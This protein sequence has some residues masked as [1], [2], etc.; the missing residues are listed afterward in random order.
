MIC[1]GAEGPISSVY[2][3]CLQGN[4]RSTGTQIHRDAGHTQMNGSTVALEATRV[5]ISKGAGQLSRTD[6]DATYCRVRDAS[7]SL[8]FFLFFHESCQAVPVRHRVHTDDT[9]EGVHAVWVEA[10]CRLPRHASGNRARWTVWF[11]FLVLRLPTGKILIPA[12]PSR[13]PYPYRTVACPGPC[14]RVR[15]STWGFRI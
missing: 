13:V 11:L 6:P 5:Y 7:A 10:P 15:C 2:T 9:L 12:G 4:T 14:E 1:P 8:A 3:T